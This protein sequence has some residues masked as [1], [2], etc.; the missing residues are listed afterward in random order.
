MLNDE[1]KRSS[2][3]I[4]HALH[5]LSWI[6]PSSVTISLAVQRKGTTSKYEGTYLP[7]YLPT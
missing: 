1:G 3:L 5:W 6:L 4:Y 7:S 2:A